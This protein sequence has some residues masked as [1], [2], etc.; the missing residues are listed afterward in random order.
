[1]NHCIEIQVDG[2][3]VTTLADVVPPRGPLRVLFIGS[4]PTPASVAAG[5]HLQGKLGKGLWKRLDEA[6][7][8]HVGPGQFADDLLLANDY[9]LTYLCKLPRPLEEDPG[10]DEYVAGW[11]QVSSLVTRH[12]PRILAFVH[13]SSLDSVLRTSFGWQHE[14]SYGFNDDLMRTF[15]RRVFAVPLPG[16]ACT[17]RE[18]R[19]HMVDLAGALNV[20]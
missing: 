6:G 10:E 13:K 15:G 16:A 5:H 12:R 14:S 7:L 9:G 19:R 1:M 18:A 4:S 8:L 17:A 3:G 20:V 2:R 11:S